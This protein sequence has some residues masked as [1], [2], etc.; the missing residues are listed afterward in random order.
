MPMPTLCPASII[1]G[2]LA[3]RGA[4]RFADLDVDQLRELHFQVIGRETASRDRAY[5]CWKLRRARPGHVPFGPAPPR[6][7]EPEA[8][9][10]AVVIRLDEEALTALDEALRRQGYRT[11]V[12]FIRHAL[13]HLLDD[14][15][16]REAAALVDDTVQRAEGTAR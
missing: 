4:A 2:Y 14:L 13:A 12:A 8:E 6:R 9:V 11:R 10:K 7:F 16:E 3:E 1:E 15:G 5:V